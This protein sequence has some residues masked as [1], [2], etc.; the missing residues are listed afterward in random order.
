MGDDREACLLWLVLRVR[1]KS[2]PWKI[3]SHNP[4][5]V[6]VWGTHLHC[7]RGL[8]IYEARN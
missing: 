8:G 5:L 6:W 7:L 1:A 4:V 2:L 3:P